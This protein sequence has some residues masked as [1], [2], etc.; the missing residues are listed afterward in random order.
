MFLHGTKRKC[1]HARGIP[2]LGATPAVVE[3]MDGIS[4]ACATIASFERHRFIPKL[5]PD[6]TCRYMH[7]LNR[8]ADMGSNGPA[9]LRGGTT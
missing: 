8:T 3:T 9:T 4:E 5:C 6:A 1:R 7:M 2:E